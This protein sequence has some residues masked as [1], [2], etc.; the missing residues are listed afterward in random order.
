MEGALTWLN[1]NQDVMFIAC[2]LAIMVI[3]FVPM[4]TPLV[5]FL[6]VISISWSMLI[7]FT[8]IYIKEP[9]EFSVFPSILLLSTAYRLALNVATTRLILANA[10]E[11]GTGAAGQVIRTFGEFVAG[12][13]PVIG[14]I[15]FLIIV[16]INFIVIT[17]GSGRIAEVAARFTLDAMPGKQMAI[18]ADL[19]AGLITENEARS[20]REKISRE[21]DFYGAMDGA[22]KFVRGDAIAGIVITIINILGGLIV[23][24]TKYNMGLSEAAETFT[25]LTIG[26]GLVSQI[27]ALVVSISSGLLVTR[28]TAK[29]QLGKEFFGQMFYEKKT[30][31]IAAVFLMLMIVT[32]LPKIQIAV[33]GI[34][35]YG[36]YRVMTKQAVEEEKRKESAK[37]VEKPPERYEPYLRLDPIELEVGFG[38]VRLVDPNQNGPLL[39]KISRMRVNTAADMGF[40]IPPIRIRDNGMLA[41]NSYV[42]KIRGAKVAE[43]SI[44]PDYYLAVNPGTAREK[45]PAEPTRDPVFGAE[46]YWV[47]ENMRAQAEELGYVPIDAATVILTHISEIIMRNADKLLTREDVNSL[48]KNL[49]EQYPTLVEDI[50]G[51]T[52]QVSDLQKVLQNMLFE[53]IPIKDLAMILEVMAE[54]C[55]KV[56]DIEIVSEYVRNSMSRTITSTVTNPDGKIYVIT[57]DPRVEEIVKA[58][59]ERTERGSY[60]NL[61]PPVVQKLVERIKYEV[62]KLTSRGFKN[63]VLCSPQIRFHFKRICDLAQPGITVVSYNEIARDSAVEAVGT[64]T[65]D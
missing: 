5:D 13:A 2:I 40:I 41:P 9:L 35:L 59:I 43:G 60:L 31:L 46:A 8:T 17:K 3:I 29:Q 61:A 10:G 28:A 48:I 37:V 20:R 63:V 16:L 30:L 23:G 21:A 44:I 47:P 25:I 22:S 18:D 38:L 45:L 12:G 54:Y 19:N 51:K 49:K 62:P 64:I 15:I 65:A 11:T 24:M 7:M 26:D 36:I 55:P 58:A 50:I 32:P 56:K 33:V 6:L 34:V 14:F 27:P 4:P 42:I 52:V 57:V 39:E 1:K 53:G